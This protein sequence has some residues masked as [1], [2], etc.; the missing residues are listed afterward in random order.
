MLLLRFFLG[1]QGYSEYS[2]SYVLTGTYDVF[3]ECL[4]VSIGEAFK[5][6]LWWW[7]GLSRT[8]V[9]GVY[10]ALCCAA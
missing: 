9:L 1:A 5:V 7:T 6:V 3:T 10:K 2:E 4:F 8:D